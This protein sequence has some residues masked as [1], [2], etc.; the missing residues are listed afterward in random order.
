MIAVVARKSSKGFPEN[1]LKIISETVETNTM[2]NTS[3]K[4][5]R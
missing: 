2:T 4:M 1:P 3:N 5:A